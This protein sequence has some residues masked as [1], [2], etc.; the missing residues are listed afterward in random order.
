MR[1]RHDFDQLTL[2]QLNQPGL[3]LHAMERAALVSLMQILLLE[4]VSGGT[5]DTSGEEIGNE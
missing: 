5:A 1:E 4:I 2:I 3:Q